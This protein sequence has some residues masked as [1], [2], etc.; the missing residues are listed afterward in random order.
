MVELAAEIQR[1][2][3]EVHERTMLKIVAVESAGNS[4]ALGVVGGQLERQPR[5]KREAIAT[6]QQLER[7]GW[8]YSVGL[9][10]INKHNFRR[11]GL[12]A[13]SA[14]EPCQ[15]LSAGAAILKE[16]YER[17]RAGR[18]TKADQQRA[19]R[20]ALSCY[21]S[22]SYTSG[23]RLGY[24]QNVVSAV[25]ILLVDTTKSGKRTRNVFIR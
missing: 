13:Q 5:S 12:T 15:N 4:Y 3:V 8:N 24:V 19:I 7:D 17:T 10:Q 23:Y 6:V 18:M 11:F 9:A 22:G 14:F 16:C 25:P 21:Y 1:C 2:A 20:D